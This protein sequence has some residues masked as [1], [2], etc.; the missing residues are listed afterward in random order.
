MIHGVAA[1]SPDCAVLVIAARCANRDPV[2]RAVSAYDAD[3]VAEASASCVPPDA[4]GVVIPSTAALATDTPNAEPA[5]AASDGGRK[6][7]SWF[8]KGFVGEKT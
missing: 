4:S 2:N 7:A 6:E 5:A 8:L 1:P 3:V